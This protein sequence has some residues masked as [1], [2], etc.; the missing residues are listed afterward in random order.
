MSGFTFKKFLGSLFI[1]IVFLTV[2]L[3][4]ITDYGETFDEFPDREI[5]EFYYHQWPS[6]GY[7]G[8]IKRFAELQRNYA[9][10]FD[11]FVVA[12]HE[13]V[14]KTLGINLPD[15]AS[16]HIGTAIISAVA[17]WVT[18]WFGAL[19]FGNWAGFL[20]AIA[21]ALYPRFIG[22]S[23]ANWKDTPVAAFFAAT[24]LVFFIAHKKKSLPWYL[25]AGIVVGLTYCIKVN[26]LIALFLAGLWTLVD[27]PKSFKIF[28]TRSVG[29]VLMFL[30]GVLTTIAVWPY[31]WREPIA[32][33]AETFR[34]FEHHNFNDYVLYLGQ[35]IRASQ[36]PWHYPFIMIGATTPILFLLF[37]FLAVI[38]A[39]MYRRSPEEKD[40]SK[41]I[42]FLLLWFFVPLCA[43]AFSSAPMYDGVRHYVSVFPAFALLVG[44]G[45][46][47][48]TPRIFAKAKSIKI[49]VPGITFGCVLG[50]N[51]AIH[52]F[53][54][55]YF[56]SLVGGGKGASELFDMDYWGQ[57][58]KQASEWVNK[59]LPT[60]STI[61][62]PFGGYVS[63]LDTTRVRP[64][65]SIR[66]KPDYKLLLLRGMMK[67]WDPTDD[68]RRPS[69]PP[70]YSIAVDGGD[71]VRLFHYPEHALLLDDS[72]LTPLFQER[73]N[74]KPD[75]TFNQFENDSF[76]G[77]PRVSIRSEIGFDCKINEFKDR[78][79][80]Q[81][82]L[83]YLKID[84]TNQYC[85]W[86][87]SD[88]HT[89]IKLNNHLI[90]KNPSTKDT[91]RQLT[92]QAGF[93]TFDLEYVNGPGEACLEFALYEGGCQ[94]KNPSTNAA[95]LHE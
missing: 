56:N 70:V 30:T 59:N 40:Q 41:T 4:N 27:L 54:I 47:V 16:H 93:Y 18:F 2:S 68:Y 64:V 15:R 89:F 19:N 25:L 73:S 92:L 5:G 45:L 34:S 95:F 87:R 17:V 22:D 42:V 72:K 50:I 1:P 38:G 6:Q 84:Q 52:P 7:D 11:V 43:Q 69:R 62:L 29:I 63:P 10:L 76:N 48:I 36:M 33:F 82:Y 71:I 78:P 79:I 39:V 23:Q 9:P 24:L 44:Y 81:R 83:G 67:D 58:L 49:I 28:F 55:V 53:Q 37:A 88:D 75:L 60:G 12:T 74:L 3:Y 86:V 51:I 8:I 90:M 32:K 91:G 35:L 66:E 14:T 31:Y 65:G 80:S 85:F 26:A 77:V 46:G 13:F 57:S 61:W 94:N 20:S 21:L